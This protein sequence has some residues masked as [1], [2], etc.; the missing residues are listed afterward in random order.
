MFR[1]WISNH[2]L[3]QLAVGLATLTSLAIV[4][5]SAS[6][7]MLR[8][9]P[10]RA[11][12]KPVP[13]D[14]IAVTGGLKNY[15]YK[16]E[17][18][19]TVLINATGTGL[20][21]LVRDDHT[22]LAGASVRFELPA[23]GISGVMA[24]REPGQYAYTIQEQVRIRSPLPFLETMNWR[25]RDLTLEIDGQ[26]ETQRL[27]L[28]E[29]TASALNFHRTDLSQAG[30]A[31]FDTPTSYSIKTHTRASF[32][33]VKADGSPAADLTATIELPDRGYKETLS[34]DA[35]GWVRIDRVD[36]M[37]LTIQGGK[38]VEI[39][40]P[41]F[42]EP[43]EDPDM[44]FWWAEPTERCDMDF[45]ASQKRLAVQP[46]QTAQFGFEV[47][48]RGNQLDTYTITVEGVPESW[49]EIEYGGKIVDMMPYFGQV[50]YVNVT[51]ERSPDTKVGT[52]TITATAKGACKE[53]SAKSTLKVLEFQQADV[54]IYGSNVSPGPKVAADLRKE[55][56]DARKD[57]EVSLIVRSDGTLPAGARLE[58]EALGGKVSREFSLVHGMAVRIAAEQVDELA[59]LGWV[60][61]VDR[62]KTVKA[63]LDHS[64]PATG[65]PELWKL[66]Y[67]GAG[68]KVAVVDTGVDYTHPAL[69]GHVILGP[70]IV[71]V[72]S[73]KVPIFFGWWIKRTAPLAFVVGHISA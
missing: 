36:E 53:L 19:R 48:N 67:D 54:D 43:P 71:K 17:D 26:D 68:V 15:E 20:T 62:N 16:L 34:T 23:M 38:M 58:V 3:R 55:L 56:G 63:L 44:L 59:A 64:V 27:T 50:V 10:A 49:V 9:G 6:V 70:D 42:I 60:A 40:G 12:G 46:G 14:S 5:A 30:L 8:A 57:A 47:V 37:K 11:G 73:R 22:A 65:A 7:V 4:A 69:K 51:P 18:S 28:A 1:L 66:G 72:V 61:R 21:Y 35:Q 29:D 45:R 25:V 2:R 31:V 13:P 33:V 52:R 24:P 32:R 41:I 39:Q